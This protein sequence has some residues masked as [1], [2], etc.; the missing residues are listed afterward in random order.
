MSKVMPNV[1][2]PTLPFPPAP[3]ANFESENHCLETII[4]STNHIWTDESK[5]RSKISQYS[6]K[7]LSTNI[8]SLNRNFM[9]IESLVSKYKPDLVCLSEIWD[10]Y[11]PKQ[12]LKDYQPIVC[13]VRKHCKGGGAAIFCRKGLSF[14]ELKSSDDL[15]LKAIEAVGVELITDNNEKVVVYS[16]YRP[17]SSTIPETL[18]DLDHLLE[19]IGDSKIIIAGDMN[20]DTSDTSKSETIKN[21]YIRKLLSFNLFQHV[22]AK[23]RIGASSSTT[24][25]HLISNVKGIETLVSNE[26]PADHQLIITL[27]GELIERKKNPSDINSMQQVDQQKSLKNMQNVKW[28][29]WIETSKHLDID[30]MYNSFHQKIQESLVY[31]SKPSRKLI[32]IHKWM[33]SKILHQKIELDK[34]RKK[35]LKK[36]TKESEIVMLEIELCKY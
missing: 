2:G 36:R 32:P 19:S 21:N 25:D 13:R 24:I 14:K 28:K 30:T 3:Q 18:L 5:I 34:L 11:G 4:K 35:F 20:L 9:E 6:Y 1:L 22:Q 12:K 33:S 8:R 17:P 15:H 29:E 27:W 31:E 10:P 16:L 7:L 23:T 26:C